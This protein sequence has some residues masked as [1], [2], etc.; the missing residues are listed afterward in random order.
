MTAIV[1]HIRS[2][3]IQRAIDL[4]VFGFGAAAL[5]LALSLTVASALG[6]GPQTAQAALEIAA[7]G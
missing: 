3:R 1:R 7:Q 6:A 2:D 4:S 5:A